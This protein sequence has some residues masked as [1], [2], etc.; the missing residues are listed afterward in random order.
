MKH[1]D[2]KIACPEAGWEMAY[3]S[4]IGISTIGHLQAIR[5]ASGYVCLYCR[6]DML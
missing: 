2:I 4:P 3:P 1:I 6:K 5:E